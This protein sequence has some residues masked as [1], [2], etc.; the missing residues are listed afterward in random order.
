MDAFFLLKD[1]QKKFLEAARMDGAL[2]WDRIC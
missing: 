1:Y 2:P